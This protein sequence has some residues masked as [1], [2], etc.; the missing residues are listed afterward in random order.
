MRARA[1]ARSPR[2]A[3][4]AG[5]ITLRY[6]AN[7]RELRR[8][9]VGIAASA[10]FDRHAASLA[11]AGLDLGRQCAASS[12]RRLRGLDA[13][14]LGGALSMANWRYLQPCMT[15]ADRPASARHQGA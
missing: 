11:S 6:T 7:R 1:R 3:G 4:M 10:E 2:L 8:P 5:C 13:G 15:T 12:D 9:H 14:R